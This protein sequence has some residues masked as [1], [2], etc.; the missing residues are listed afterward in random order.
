MSSPYLN[1]CL[2]GFSLIEMLIGAIL[3]SILLIGFGL[4]GV[5]IWTQ[6]SYE[7]VCAKVDQYGNNVLDN[8]SDSFKLSNVQDIG[9]RSYDGFDVV[10]V[11]RDDATN[12]KYDIRTIAQ[13]NGYELNELE[14][15]DDSFHKENESSNLYYNEFEKKGYATSITEFRCTPI[16]FTPEDNKYGATDGESGDLSKSMYIVDLQ[17]TIYKM[18]S[19]RPEIYN[20]VDFQRTLYITNEFIAS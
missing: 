14:I 11:Q 20:T 4:L 10:T 15:N 2:K 3:S 18:I 1:N 19:G 17:I 8:M 6:I 7:D 13:S 5:G 9:L 16:G 12:I